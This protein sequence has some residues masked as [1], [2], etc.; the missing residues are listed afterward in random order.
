MIN[1]QR[2]PDDFYVICDNESTDASVR[3]D[4][5]DN[6][7]DVYL[8]ACESKPRYVCLRWNYRA[9]EPVSVLGDKWERGYADMTWKSLD[10]ENFMPWYFLAT[11]GKDTVGCGV[12]TRPESF[13]CFQ[14]DASGVT[15]WFDVRCG[16]IGVHLEGREIKIGTVVTREYADTPSFEAACR[17]CKVLCPDPILPSEPVYGGNNWY[18]AYG[19]SSAD[20]ICSDSKLIADLSEGNE[21]RPFM[22][23]DDGWQENPTNGPWLPNSKFGDMK[24]L[25]DKMKAIGVRPGIWV[26][27][28][29]N[30]DVET[31]HPEWTIR[32]S[33]LDPTVDEVKELIRSDIRRIKE[34]GYELIKHDYTTYDLFGEFGFDFNGSVS[35]LQ[36]WS[37]ADKTKTSAQ[38]VLDLYRLIREEAGDTLII[39]CN[40]VS[41]LS[42]GLVELSRVG[43]DTSGAE[44]NRTR[45][46]GV[47][48]LAFRL[49]QNR[50]F[51]MSDADCVGII[52]G[53]IDWTLNYEWTK[54]LA[55][56]GTPLFISCPGNGLTP[57]QFEQM[58]EAFAYAAK[59]TDIAIPLD[60]EY[61]NQP[62]TWLING[63]KV[64]FDFVKN[65]Y[66]KLLP[67]LHILS[68]SIG[69]D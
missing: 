22:V 2:L 50:A 64:E 20:E 58:K 17:F 8:R 32:N 31:A 42:A 43:D 41:H 6:G 3:F 65:S 19:N 9:E 35:R 28:L 15:G 10:G 56:S 21:V 25:A 44:W 11:N 37:F 27:F 12:M 33:Y 52:P 54:L 61:N 63:E 53:K 68:P 62:Q 36:G 67:R 69:R 45:A 40:T 30:S 60:W 55:R 5:T 13:V 26:R 49:P 47:N 59:Q 14:Y 38:V 4:L 7:L 29:H 23:I 1:I 39:G 34:W 18:Y 66:P 57:E 16:D 46:M 24:V 51:Y 48:A